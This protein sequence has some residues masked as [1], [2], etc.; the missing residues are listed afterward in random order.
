VK[1]Y[2]KDGGGGG[3]TIRD[4]LLIHQHY[5]Q[6]YSTY[7]ANRL[8]KILDASS[9]Q[10]KD[11]LNKSKAIETKAKYHRI[12]AEIRR[13][14]KDLSEQLYSAFES[15]GLDLINEEMQFV[16]KTINR[17]LK[18]SLDLPAAK[19]VWA[20]ASFASYSAD[21][22]ETFETYLN[23]LSNNL[24]KVW[25]TNVRA[26]YLAGLTARQI[27]R[28]VLGS[29][30]DM[31]PGQ[32]QGLRR[33]LERNTQTMVSS[34]AETA[35]DA[36]YKE[37]ESI[38]DGYQYLATLD[39]RT[40]LVCAADDGKIFKSLDE[41]PKLPAHHNCILGDTRI[42]T[43]ANISN[44]FR[45][46]YEGEIIVITTASGNILRCTP[47]HPI[48]CDSGF[49][50]AKDIK[51]GDNLVSNN[52]I[53][54]INIFGKNKD[55]KVSTIE[56]I[57]SSFGKSCGMSPISMPLSP[58]DFHGDV[59][60]KKVDVI[61]T[62]RKF[63]LKLDIILDKIFN[64]HGL[65]N[66]ISKNTIFVPCN[67]SLVHFFRGSYFAFKCF[68][69]SFSHFLS[70]F[71]SRKFH[72]LYLLL[73]AV[74]RLNPISIKKAGHIHSAV[75]KPF[76]NT[77]NP[78]AMIVKIKNILNIGRLNIPSGG[79]IKTR[80]MQ[81]L[82]DGLVIDPDLSRNIFNRYKRLI[83]TDNV[84]SVE[85]QWFSGHVYNLE[86]KNNWYLANNII[87]HNCRC[88]YV[89]YIKGFE[90]IPGERAAMDGPVSDKLTYKDWLAQQDP[91]IQKEILGSTMYAA[92]KNGIPISSF[93][94]DGRILTLPQI[95]K[96]EGLEFFG[97]GLKTGSRQAQNAYANTYY[98]SIRNRRNPTDV[99]RI[100][101]H[102]GFS[103]DEI[104]SIRR[105][106]FTDEHDLGDGDYGRFAS[107]WRM[108]Q[109]WQ[110]M[111]QGWN[112]ND[113]VKYRDYDLLLLK[114]ELEEL[115]QMAKYG[116]NTIEAH[117]KA[118]AKY[119]WDVKIK[120]LE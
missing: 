71:I 23:G 92:Y 108:A 50:N 96:K 91:A 47:N 55:D 49:I 98:E 9:T 116:Y 112:G 57:F 110:R 74:T 77:F 7:E 80:L 42:S 61:R 95:M 94:S 37:N 54:I 32:I 70:L 106:V 41:A 69:S 22:H 25:D 28:A 97:A 76:G 40:C 44:V 93:V 20:A 81:N 27:N 109:A 30:K 45:R 31:E 100:A 73:F 14:Q 34:L 62:T 82:P 102:T 38:F 79:G 58:E 17:Y 29:V 2:N 87:I 84:V 119:P 39:T 75:T 63:S 46:V 90:D 26:G 36:I 52:G 99:E 5:L 60:D 107:N 33:S 118:E 35:R 43:V 16:E 18:T 19:Q 65:I 8:L 120:E 105:H 12:A 115:T 21:G 78:N 6:R 101:E 56:N 104:T 10:I 53:K 66:R 86:T 67:G 4:V 117:E 103:R 88:L 111:E 15:D 72:S 113:M 83:K 11:L 85:R 59:T 68:A 89:P 3:G 51:Q 1:L 64:K 24:Y 48:L 13:I 114:H